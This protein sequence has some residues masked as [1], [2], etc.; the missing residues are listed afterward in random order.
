MSN[1]FLFFLRQKQ[2]QLFRKSATFGVQR[3]KVTFCLEKIEKY[4]TKNE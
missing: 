2:M 4:Q 3:K 1:E